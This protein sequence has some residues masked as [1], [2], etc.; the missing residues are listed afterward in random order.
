MEPSLIKCGQSNM[1]NVAGFCLQERHLLPMLLQAATSGPAP[2]QRPAAAAVANLC[3]DP[4]LVVG[5]LE[6]QKGLA[7][8][9]A[10]LVAMSHSPDPGVQVSTCGLMWVYCH[11]RKR[12]IFILGF[13]IAACVRPGA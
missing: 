7:A 6:Q 2:V 4:Q 1:R 12:S 5:T 3:A 13:A 8:L 10:A 11:V 9:V